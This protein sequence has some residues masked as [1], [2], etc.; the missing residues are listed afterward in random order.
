MKS[1]ATLVTWPDVLE[2]SN[3][4]FLAVIRLNVAHI[5][6]HGRRTALGFGNL[7][8]DDDDDAWFESRNLLLTCNL[9]SFLRGSPTMADI[10]ERDCL[11]REVMSI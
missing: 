8:G 1:P 3:N 9:G 6:N 4:N 5:G 10:T 2:V 11:F 7:V